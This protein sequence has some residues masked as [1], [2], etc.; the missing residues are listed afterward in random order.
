M[1]NYRYG[2]LLYLSDLEG[3]RDATQL[4]HCGINI[5]VSIIAP[6]RLPLVVGFNVTAGS[7]WL[8][9]KTTSPIKMETP[10]RTDNNFDFS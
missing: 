8:S 9:R 3:Q 4:P 7:R 6:Y 2:P 10:K 5:I 1:A